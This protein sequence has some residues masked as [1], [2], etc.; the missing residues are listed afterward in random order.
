[1]F[2]NGDDGDFSKDEA[3]DHEISDAS[4]WQASAGGDSEDNKA[5]LGVAWSEAKTF[6]TLV[7]Y[8]ESA[9]AKT[10]GYRVET[11]NTGNESD[12]NKIDFTNSRQEKKADGESIGKDAYVDTVSLAN[13][14]TAK[15]VR[16]VCFDREGK[17]NPSIYEFEVYAGAS[18][19]SPRVVE[20]AEQTSKVYIFRVSKADLD[21]KGIVATYTVMRMFGEEKR[22]LTGTLNILNAYTSI[23]CGDVETKLSDFVGS[24][25]NDSYLIGVRIDGLQA[26]D[27]LTVAIEAAKAV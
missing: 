12:W 25:E 9:R 8:W 19:S 24:V 6:K 17:S 7:I 20:N 23:T 5:I 4:R 10:D 2:S 16:V 15:Y 22:Q 27:E 3:N 18:N 13:A 11:S 1:M 26:D 14:V 21:G